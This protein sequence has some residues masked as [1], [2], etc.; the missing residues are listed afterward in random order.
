VNGA[1][2]LFKL[3]SSAECC[4]FQQIHFMLHYVDPYRV[5]WLG[6]FSCNARIFNMLLWMGQSFCSS[7]CRQLK[8]V[9][10]NT[11]HHVHC[12][13]RYT[14]CFRG[15][16]YVHCRDFYA[17]SQNSGERLLASSCMNVRTSAWSNPTTT[18]MMFLKYCGF[19]SNIKVSLNSEKNNS[20]FTSRT[21]YI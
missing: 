17:H 14:V 4:Q 21:M 19:V 10:F 16:P 12:T 9:S 6:P 11:G 13:D 15:P 5:R 3:L 20:F 18:G 2:F 1:V 8:A 7:Y